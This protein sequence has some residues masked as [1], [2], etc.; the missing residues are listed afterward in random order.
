MSTRLDLSK[1]SLM[2]ALDLAKLIEYE[3]YRR[4]KEFAAQLGR[5]DRA[6]PTMSVTSALGDQRLR[7]D[8]G[9]RVA[10]QSR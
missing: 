7:L 2:D 1:L 9:E 10:G 3:A 6:A 4:Y 8:P 5:K